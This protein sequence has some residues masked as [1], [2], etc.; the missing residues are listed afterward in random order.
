[1]GGLIDR[2]FDLQPE[3]KLMGQNVSMAGINAFIAN[4]SGSRTYMTTNHVAQSLTLNNGEEKIIQS[5]LE[6]QLGTNTFSVKVEEDAKVVGILNRYDGFLSSEL[7]EKPIEMLIFVVYIETGISDVLSIPYHFTLHQYFGFEYKINEDVLS[8]LRVG[9][10]IPAGTILADSPAI[11]DNSGYAFGINANTVLLAIPEVAEDGII[12]SNS[13]SKRLA[14]TIFETRVINI[15]VNKFLLNL[16]GDINNFKPFPDIGEKIRPDGILL[17]I[18]SLDTDYYPGMSSVA[19]LQSFDPYLDEITFLKYG[20][21]VTEVLENGELK[22]VDTGIVT[23]IKIYQNLNLKNKA[24]NIATNTD[25]L[26]S[27]AAEFRKHEKGIV[28][29]Y[30]EIKKNYGENYS[31]RLRNMIHE[32]LALSAERGQPPMTYKTVP[33]EHYRIEVTVKHVVT[34]KIG[35]KITDLHGCKGVIVGIWDDKD[36]PVDQFGN[37]ADVISDPNSTISR[38]NISR[39]YE[40]YFSIASRKCRDMVRAE[41]DDKKAFD[42]ILGLLKITN[43]DQYNFYLNAA[44]E[45]KIEILKDVRERELFL[46][47]QVRID[48]LSAEKVIEIE[49]SIYKPDVKEIYIDGSKMVLTKEKISIGPLFTI[50]LNKVAVDQINASS[51]PNLNHYGFPVSMSKSN[52]ATLGFKNNA[53]KIMSETESR[54]FYAYAKNKHR[55]ELLAEIKD[56]GTAIPTNNEIWKNILEAEKPSNIDNLV[57]REKVPLGQD[58]ALRL[59]RNVLQVSGI[60]L[61]YLDDPKSNLDTINHTTDPEKGLN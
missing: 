53:V 10:I 33:L 2:L 8:N 9:S 45:E 40:N 17:G 55:S 47:F 25:I 42:L 4:T 24:N 58:S 16:Y 59:I 14:Y 32:A 30:R 15:P 31:P 52:R 3:E 11:K 12:I 29:I 44:D 54:L 28:N 34:P 7:L 35:S 41:K 49:N 20:G 1:M 51:S 38:S 61:E 23:D 19:D 37:V 36:C 27:Y 26:A 60:G 22:L 6:N 43:L 21:G 48:K 50:V 18:R 5:G 57:D 13:F 46:L 39:L 56:R